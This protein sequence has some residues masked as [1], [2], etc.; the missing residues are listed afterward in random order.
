MRTPRGASR[1]FREVQRTSRAR[2]EGRN[3]PIVLSSSRMTDCS[4]LQ[5]LQ[6]LLKS[7]QAAPQHGAASD[8]RAKPPPGWPLGS[9]GAHSQGT[10]VNGSTYLP[11]SLEAPRAPRLPQQTDQPIY[12]TP[13]APIGTPPDH[14]GSPQVPHGRPNREL[15]SCMG[16]SKMGEWHPGVNQQRRRKPFTHDDLACEG[17]M[18]TS[19]QLRAPL[20]PPRAS[21]DFGKVIT[22]PRNSREMVMLVSN[23]FKRGDLCFQWYALVSY[24]GS[25]IYI[26][27]YVYVYICNN[28]NNNTSKIHQSNS[29]RTW[30]MGT[31]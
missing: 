17:T 20:G 10:P 23:S 28:N 27:I 22:L 1:R 13:G 16:K 18:G 11:T 2:P 8:R 4:L 14:Q 5:G 25:Y 21:L 29:D 9:L 12:T 24:N 6:G 3:K 30:P 31:L 19:R 7:L 26:Y 15:K